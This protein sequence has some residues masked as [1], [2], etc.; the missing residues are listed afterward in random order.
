MPTD[1]VKF[2]LLEAIAVFV[3]ERIRMCIRYQE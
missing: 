2:G 1:K 3:Y